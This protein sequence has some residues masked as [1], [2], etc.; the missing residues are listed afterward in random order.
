MAMTLIGEGGMQRGRMLRVAAGASPA[1]Y[2]CSKGLAHRRRERSGTWQT[3]PWGASQARGVS[4]QR[5]VHVGLRG[6]AGLCLS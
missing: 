4:L 3:G 5:C 2:S 6:H 1:R